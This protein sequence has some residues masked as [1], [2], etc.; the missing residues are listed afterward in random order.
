MNIKKIFILILFT[1]ISISVFSQN[2][3]LTKADKF[4][5]VREYFKAL[6]KY[7]DAYKDET[8]K[9][10]KAYI[11][12]QMA[13]CY[14]FMNNTKKAEIKYKNCIQKK[15]SNPL[16][17]LYYADMLKSNEKYSL[18]VEQYKEYMKLVPDDE[19]GK[20]GLESCSLA[21]K[22]RSKPTRYIINNIKDINTKEMEFSAAYSN[23]ECNEIYFTSTRKKDNFTKFNYVS[24]QNF[25]DIFSSDIDKKGEWSEPVAIND[26]I[27]SEFDDGSPSFSSN[28]RT[29]YFTRCRVKKNE[30]IGCQIY[31]SERQGGEDWKTTEVMQIVDDSI[32]VGHP[33]ISDDGNTLY[34]VSRME[35]G[36][37]END[38]WMIQKKGGKWG[39]PKN[40][41]PDINTKGNEVYPYIRKNGVLYFSSDYHLGMGGLDIFKAQKIDGKWDVENMKYPINSYSDDFAISFKGEDEEGLFTSTRKITELPTDPPTVIKSRGGDDIYSFILPPLKFTLEGQVKD[42]TTDEPIEGA[43]IKLFGSDGMDLKIKTDKEG[44]FKYNLHP[45]TDYVYVISKSGYL[46]GKGR[47]STTKYI[48]SKKLDKELFLSQIEKPVEVPNILY[49]FGKWDLREES[50]KEL[51]KLVETLKSNPNIVI[52]LGS[53]T[54][55]V[56]DEKAN[57]ELS[58]K[59]AQSVVDYLIS[60]GIAA[61]RLT[62]KGYGES[63]PYTV[64]P[65][66]AKNTSLNEN[67]F[68][69]ESFFVKLEE[70]LKKVQEDSKMDEAKKKYKIDEINK[71]IEE[72]N[73]ANRRTEFRVISTKFIP[74]IDW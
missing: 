7:K 72:A 47:E 46:N 50:K 60:K 66:V 41:G 3:K 10:Q 13:E 4:F 67:D 74:D 35:G 21:D 25:T 20:R 24:G 49:D 37:G 53:H 69:D 51:D 39:K 19:R 43:L 17:V 44:K 58:Q 8:D 54:D 62:A 27:D 11:T 48:Y 9:R 52:E 28:Y 70:E 33:S 30:Q 38:I 18:A 12:Y 29:L 45:N 73:Q 5:E 55:R 56:G 15:Y 61:E 31:K 68:L 63:K 64:S 6:E 26:T 34:F 57:I 23:S 14:R 32:S 2:K 59:R 71:K 1:T 42:Q 40:L 22:W 65:R 16:A 36:Y